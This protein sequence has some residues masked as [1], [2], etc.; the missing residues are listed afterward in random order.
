MKPHA[1]YPNA[2]EL[3]EIYLEPIISADETAGEPAEDEVEEVEEG[4][5]GSKLA[6]SAT[7]PDSAA[8]DWGGGGGGGGGGEGTGAGDGKEKRAGSVRA[9]DHGTYTLS[10]SMVD[11]G[12]YILHVKV[13]GVQAGR[14]S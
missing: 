2:Q 7:S 3:V 12:R 5:K 9:C 14:S 6:S 10:Y 8:Q 1:S 13:A 11:S 4:A